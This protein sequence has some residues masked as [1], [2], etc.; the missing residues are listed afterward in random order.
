[1][2]EELV[3]LSMVGIALTMKP[4]Q[5]KHAPRFKIYVI[6][7]SALIGLVIPVAMGLELDDILHQDSKVERLDL[8]TMKIEGLPSSRYD[9]GDALIVLMT[10]DCIHCKEAVIP[11]NIYADH[12]GF[13][14]IIALSPNS[15]HEVDAFDAQHQPVYSIGRV[16]LKEFQR[17]LHNNTVPYYLLL[18]QHRVVQRWD[19]Y[20][21]EPEELISIISKLFPSLNKE[22]Q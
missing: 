15:E 12:P 19:G 2:V 4:K 6:I 8:R 7:S 9:K 22:S 14:L 18:K 10:T 1:M 16:A 17:L 13:P 20:L 3:M 5:K 21:P 11:L